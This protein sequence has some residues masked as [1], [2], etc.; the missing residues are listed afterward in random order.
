M[1]IK[2]EHAPGCGDN[3]PMFSALTTKFVSESI[4]ENEPAY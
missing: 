4:S 3:F 1:G 2:A